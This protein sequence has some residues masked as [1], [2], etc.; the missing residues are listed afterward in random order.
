MPQT[1]S[2]K[3]TDKEKE[4]ALRFGVGYVKKNYTYQSTWGVEA[5]MMGRLYATMH[6]H[7]LCK[8]FL[9]HSQEPSTHE[10]LFAPE[11][12]LLKEMIIFERTLE[13]KVGSN[14]VL[15]ML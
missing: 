11:T 2:S 10:I 8:N 9:L 12:I 14:I 3:T 4:N 7:R 1:T 13:F 6:T 5:S 15:S